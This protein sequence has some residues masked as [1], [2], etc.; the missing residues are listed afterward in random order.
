MRRVEAVV[1]RGH[2]GPEVLEIGQ[3]ELRDPGPGE[4]LVEVAAAG[5]NRADLL[6]RM[7]RY[8]AP[9]GVPPEVPGLELSGVVARVG[10]GVRLWKPGDRVMAVVGG[11]AMAREALVPER[12]LL[13]VPASMGL[14]E[15]AAV[16]EA[17][18]TAWDALALQGGLRAGTRLLVHAAGSGVG[19]AAVQLG[20]W[21]GAQV[22]GTSRSAWKLERCAGL[23]L[24]H[25][26]LVRDGRF[27]E[28]VRRHVPQGVDLVLELVGGDYL[29]ES[30][31]ALSERG[32]LVLV[33][34]LGGARAT[35]PL[36]EVLSRRIELRGTVLRSRPPEEKAA[37]ARA[38]A[39]AVLPAFEAGR[40]RPVLAEVLPMAAVAEAHERMA[41][42]ELFGKLVLAWE[43]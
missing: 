16:P 10:P 3:V 27:A 38:F 37:L 19:T 23:G 14:H 18:L 20:R 26:V 6:Q 15:A 12:E 7:G 2:G 30:V 29:P 36:G 13:A 1:L 22:L 34:L 5:L 21:A 35:L 28:A 42:G 25:G 33:G 17:F 9:P 32:R 41:R 24:E 8:P 11:G 4:V 39:R 40:L 43:G 31:R